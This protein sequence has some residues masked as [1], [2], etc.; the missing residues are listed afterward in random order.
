MRVYTR[1]GDD[2]TTALS[3]GTRLSKAAARVA[4]YGDVD[5]LNAA[6]GVLLTEEIPVEAATALVRAQ[7]L[8]FDVGA[9]LADPSGRYALP[10]EA[11]DPAWME[12]WIDRMDG[13]LAPL[14]S[15]ILPGGCRAA[16][17]A[18]QART[19]CRRAERAVVALGDAGE[20]LGA[21]VPILNRLSDALFVLARWLNARA[22]EHDRP[23]HGRR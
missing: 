17:L 3:D 10:V 19:T 23:W 14:A 7:S 11:A 4:A 15:F 18:H 1:R 9:A 12:Q 5:E 6:L 21:A 8:L 2:G 20:D 22:G 16:A 13:E